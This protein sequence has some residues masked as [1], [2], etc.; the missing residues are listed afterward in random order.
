MSENDTLKACVREL[1][2]ILRTEKNRTAGRSVKSA[3]KATAEAKGI[4]YD[5]L[6]LWQGYSAEGRKY[7]Q[8]K[9]STR[10]IKAN[11]ERCELAREI[12]SLAG[13]LHDVLLLQEVKINGRRKS[14][15]FH[16]DTI[17]G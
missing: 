11:T 6:N 8:L 15:Q 5:A 1:K 16:I 13:A 4:Y 7:K 3:K 17:R 10:A 9:A 12:V 2:G 14:L